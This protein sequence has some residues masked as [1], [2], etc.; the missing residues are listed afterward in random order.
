MGRVRPCVPA[1]LALP[2]LLAGCGGGA[3]S[4]FVQPPPPVA[5]FSISIPSGSVTINQGASSPAVNVTVNALNGFTGNVQVTLSG[6]PSGVTSNPASP[7]TAV[8]GTSTAVVFGVAANAATGNFT[9]MAQ[10]SSGALSHSANLS[11]TIQ[12][13]IVAALPRTTFVRTDS[14]AAM[15]NPPGEPRHRHIGYD[16]ARKQLFVANRAMNRVEILSSVDLTRKSQ[17]AVPAASSA[18][19]SADGATLWVGTVTNQAIAIDPQSLQIKT[20]Y[21]SPMLAPLPNA[22]FDRPE[23]LLAMSNGNLMVRL[24][25]ASR[26]EALLAFWNPATNAIANLTS[27][28]PQLFQN[29]LGAIARTG[30]PSRPRIFNGVA[31]N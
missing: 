27:A 16:S 10:G 21:T 11:L 13:G 26:P 14:V 15:D 7:F 28:E 8:A 3:S 1:V 31:T 17:I 12:P 9:I 29:G 24:R 25:Q 23:E 2:L 19:L 22:P 6:V 30:D 5:D 20:R 4:G 18:D